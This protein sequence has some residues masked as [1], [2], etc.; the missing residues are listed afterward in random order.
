MKQIEEIPLKELLDDLVE[1]A[2][3]IGDCRTCKKLGDVS[4]YDEANPEKSVDY[5]I[6]TNEKIIKVISA[7]II[8]R[9]END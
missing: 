4:A 6:E 3:D 2:K 1:S 5:R 9:V 8:R 7:E